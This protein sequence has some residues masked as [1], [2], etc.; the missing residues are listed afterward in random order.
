MSPAPARRSLRRAARPR[1]VL[2]SACRCSRPRPAQ[3]PPGRSGHLTASGSPIPT[4][5]WDVVPTADALP[6]PGLGGRLLHQ[7]RLQRGDHQQPLHPDP[8]VPRRAR[9]TGGSR[10]PTAP[11]PAAGASSQTTIAPPQVPADLTVSPRRHRPAARLAA[12]HPWQPV[13]GATGYDDRDGRRGRRRR[14]HPRG[15]IRTTTY[16]WPDPQGVGER[17]GTEDFFVRVR[18]RSTTTSRAT[19]PAGSGTTSPSC[20]PSPRPAAPPDW[21]APPTRRPAC[22]PAVTVQDVVLDWD[23]VKGAKQYEIWVA[24][25]RDFN[26]QVEKRIVY[27][28]RY[29]PPTTYDNNNYFWKVRAYN[30]AEPAHPV[31]RHPQRLPAPLAA[32]RPRWSTRRSTTTPA[33]GD[34]L[35]FQWTPVRHAT[36]YAPRRGHRRQLH[37]GHLHDLPDRL[38]DLHPRLPSSDRVHAHP[39]LAHLLAGPRL[40]PDPRRSPRGQRRLLRHGPVRLQQRARQ[41]PSA[42]PTARRVDGADDPRGSPATDAERVHRSTSPELPGEERVTDDHAPCRGRPPSRCPPTATR[43]TPTRL[44]DTFV[45]R[46][47]AID[48]DGK[49]LAPTYARRTF[50]RHR[51]APC[52]GRPPLTPLPPAR[53]PDHLAVPGPGV[54]ALRLRAGARSTTSSRCPRRPAIVFGDRRRPR[55]SAA[56]LSYPAVTDLG[57]YFLRPGT[58]DWWV[59]ARRQHQPSSAPAPE[60]PSPSRHPAKVDGPAGRARRPG[61]R[62]RQHLQQAARRRRGATVCQGRAGHAGPRLGRRARRRRLPGLRL[63]G[64]RLHQPRPR[65]RRRP[66]TRAGP[67]PTATR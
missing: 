62:R 26:N 27:S 21:S 39:G 46:S 57:D 5:S 60:A 51:D 52:R 4:L 7:P 13:A 65:R 48:G 30:A 67:R 6:R 1:P 14:R 55:C 58:Y 8:A 49:S 32:C 2:R 31:A 44:P 45:W 53:R 56:R 36:R 40:R 11:A 43:P 24:L 15:N 54:A 63:R 29:S 59:E 23:P 66:S 35:Y 47:S 9:S 10:P 17:E 42:R 25:D 3:A 18:A 34:D 28:T 16:V 20:R 50:V 61:R 38:D 33:V 22:A 37:A 19:G 41:R 64:P 12:G